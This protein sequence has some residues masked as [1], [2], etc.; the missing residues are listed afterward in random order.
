MYDNDKSM[1]K[2]KFFSFDQKELLWIVKAVLYV[3]L[4][5]DEAMCFLIVAY[6]FLCIFLFHVKEYICINVSVIVFMKE[7]E[8]SSG[9]QLIVAENLLQS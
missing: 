3:I 4:A 6:N 1:L 2:E 8:D 5:C 7:T 9:L